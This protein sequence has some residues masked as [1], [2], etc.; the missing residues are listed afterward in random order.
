MVSGGVTPRLPAGYTELAWI[1]T[2]SSAWI[3]TNIIPS[4]AK[5]TEVEMVMARVES[6]PSEGMGSNNNLN[7]NSPSSGKW[8]LV[9]VATTVDI[10]NGEFVNIVLKQTSSGRFYSINGVS[11]YGSSNQQANK[12]YLGALGGSSVGSYRLIAKF[13]SVRVKENNVLVMD[14]VPAMRDSDSVVGMYDLA[15]NTFL[16]NAGTGTFSYGTL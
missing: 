7:I 3:N 15:N 1:Q 4:V 13:K 9:A 10:V 5:E 16:T 6:Y 12:F 8:K 14:L 2:N 11:G